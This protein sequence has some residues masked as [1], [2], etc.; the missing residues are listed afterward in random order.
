M[1]SDSGKADRGQPN[2]AW[3]VGLEVGD[4]GCLDVLLGVAICL[5]MHLAAARGPAT[6]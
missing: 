2:E 1:P 3:S 6:F 4:A 5:L